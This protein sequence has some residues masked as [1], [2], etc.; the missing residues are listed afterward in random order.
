MGTPNWPLSVSPHAGA[1]A[2]V[3]KTGPN[4]EYL[5]F[6]S[7]SAGQSCACEP[8]VRVKCARMWR[9]FKDK[10]R[11]FLFLMLGEAQREKKCAVIAAKFSAAGLPVRFAIDG[12][13][14][15]GQAA[16]PLA[17]MGEALLE[18]DRLVRRT[19]TPVITASQPIAFSSVP[20]PSISRR[21]RSPG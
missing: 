4:R 11:N 17:A 18:H 9:K 13:G 16:V 3:T 21:M 10:A 5:W 19:S 15:L 2:G 8:R 12:A 1:A 14:N 20:M 7:L 6:E